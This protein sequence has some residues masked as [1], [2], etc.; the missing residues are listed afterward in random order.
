MGVIAALLGELNN[1]QLVGFLLMLMGV[2]T[3]IEP[4]V[5]LTSNGVQTIRTDIYKCTDFSPFRSEITYPPPPS[6]GLMRKYRMQILLG[7]L[8]PLVF[9]LTPPPQM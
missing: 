6:L 1:I 7:V 8:S 9:S 5:G 2:N 4:N 3:P